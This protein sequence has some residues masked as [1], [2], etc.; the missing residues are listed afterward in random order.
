MNAP[1]LLRWIPLCLTAALCDRTAVAQSTDASGKVEAEPGLHRVTF[2]A[3]EGR[4]HVYVPDDLAAG[5]TITGITITDSFGK[6]DPER[7]QSAKALRTYSL[8]FG[9]QESGTIQAGFTWAVPPALSGGTLDLA[10]QD[11]KGKQIA[12]VTLPVAPKAEPGP[13]DLQVPALIQTGRL[14]RV[15]GRFD[16]PLADISVRLGGQE[17]TVMARSPRMIVLRNGFQAPGLTE[18][19]VREG[20]RTTKGELRNVGVQLSAQ[21]LNLLKGETTT[22]TLVLLGLGGIKEAVSVEL[23]NKSSTVLSM[24][25][26]EKQVLTA[27][28]AQIQDGTFKVQ[29]V[30]TGIQAGSFSINTNLVGSPTLTLKRD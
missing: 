6:D 21:K 15:R 4:I 23:E 28:P 27:S 13:A 1:S 8:K 2:Q 24:E 17:V 20:S 14:F 7:A 11:P 25:G 19:E 22:L 12:K 5:D 30:L 9:A 18:I 3:P 29:R 10:L 16:G 26:G